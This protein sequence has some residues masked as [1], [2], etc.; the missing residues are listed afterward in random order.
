M[1][2]EADHI[3]NLYNLSPKISLQNMHIFEG[4]N[5]VLIL[6]GI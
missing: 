1:K 2:E 4:D 6:A 3:I 5:I